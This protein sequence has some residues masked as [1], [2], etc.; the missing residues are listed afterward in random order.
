MQPQPPLQRHRLAPASGAAVHISGRAYL[1]VRGSKGRA[2]TEEMTAGDVGY[3]PQ[4]VRP[5]HMS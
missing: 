4:R 5:L 1:G 3:L 2:R